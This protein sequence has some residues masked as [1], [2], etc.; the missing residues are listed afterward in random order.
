[1]SDFFS[2]PPE[3]RLLFVNNGINLIAAILILVLGWTVARLAARWTRIGLDRIPH[4]DPTLRPL[5]ASFIRYGILAVTI[6]AVLQRFG[7]ETTSLIA[8]LG[9]AGLAIGLAMQNTLAN[10]A[11]G[12]MLLMVRPFRVGDKI[13]AGDVKGVVREIELFRTVVITD[14]MLYLSVPNSTIFAAIIVNET[15]ETRR[16]FNIP[17]VLDHSSDIAKARTIIL[18]IMAANPKVLKAPLPAV[19]IGAIDQNGVTLTA[20]GFTSNADFGATR[21]AVQIEIFRRMSDE[22][23]VRFPRHV[24]SLRGGPFLVPQQQ[25]DGEAPRPS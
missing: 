16:R 5:V 19:P 3:M 14:D 23:S 11:A 13:Q 15:R 20:Q 25:Q 18:D 9:A 1:M 21:D 6:I 4:F 2:L 12:V 24:V 8:V 17:I 22:D 10:V 7:V